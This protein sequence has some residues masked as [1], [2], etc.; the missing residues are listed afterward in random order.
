MLTKFLFRKKYTP[1]NVILMTM[2]RRKLQSTNE[3]PTRQSPLSF[4]YIGL[5]D[6]YLSE[7]IERNVS[8]GMLFF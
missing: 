5:Y 3:I 8:D 7:M 6:S 4:A 1:T 2:K